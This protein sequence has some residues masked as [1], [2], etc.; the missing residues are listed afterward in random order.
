MG[1]CLW[2]LMFLRR[3]GGEH[4]FLCKEEFVADFREL[5]A[6]TAHYI[7]PLS[8]WDGSG[9]DCWIANANFEGYGLHYSGQHDI[10]GF[11]MDFF[12]QM[13][14]CHFGS[15]AFET[16][17]DMLWDSACIGP[18]KTP[19]LIDCLIV[20]ADPR[21]GQC[22]QFSRH[23]LYDQ[24]VVPMISRYGKV[25]VANSIHG[26]PT[27]YSLAQIGAMA[28]VAH[29]IICLANGP[30]WTTFNRWVDAE[31][32]VFLDPMYIDFGGD[33]YHHAANVKQAR[34]KMNEI[35]WL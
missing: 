28:T 17:A 23:E 16:R 29:R 33:K 12:N 4:R 25:V 27:G 21:S 8:E 14:M 9:Q 24:I 32:L 11:V 10:M 1:D 30:A 15:R 2:A 18:P 5:M 7:G 13:A 19:K 6:D 26:E 22:L 31:R 3:V 34:E 35:R 20:C